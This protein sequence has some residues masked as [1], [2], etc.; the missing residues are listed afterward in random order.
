M[1][2]V[3]HSYIKKVFISLLFS[4]DYIFFNLERIKELQCYSTN[5]ICDI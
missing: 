3:L 2:F 4:V 1:S 5:L